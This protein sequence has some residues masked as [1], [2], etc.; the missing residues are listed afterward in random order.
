VKWISNDADRMLEKVSR[1][2]GDLVY[3]ESDSL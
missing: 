3:Q 2:V 1:L